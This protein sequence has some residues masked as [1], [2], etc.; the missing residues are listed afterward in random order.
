MTGRTV[1][2]EVALQRRVVVR[3][4]LLRALD[5]SSARARLLVA[6]AGYGKTTLAEQWI[7]AGAR[8]AAW[9]AAR[10]ASAD[11][12]VLSSALAQ[13]AATI[14]DGC[15]AR[16]RE[17]LTST[18][19]PADEAGVL[20]EI[21]AEDLQEWPTDAWLVIDDY[22]RL[23]RATEAEEFV[24]VLHS[25]APVNLLVAS[26]QRPSW[27]SSRAILYGEV[28]ELGQTAL[29]M[30]LEEAEEVLTEWPSEQAS[31]LTRLAEGWP[32]VVG[33][34]GLT[35]VPADLDADVP[36]ELYEF[37]AEE[38]YES[39][40][41]E[42]R[43]GL[44]L[45]AVAPVLD[46]ELAAAILGD[47][48]CEAVFQEALAKGVLDDRHD[49]LELHPLARG[50]LE[51]R[52]PPVSGQDEA[53][54]CALQA[55]RSKRDWDAA[56][57]VL[58]RHGLTHELEGLLE[59]ALDDLLEGARVTTLEAWI[60]HAKERQRDGAIYRIAQAEL[61]VRQGKHRAAQTFAES[62]L[63]LSTI[64][65]PLAF[66]AL[67]IAGRAD[68]VACREAEGLERFRRAEMLADTP[69]ERRQAQLGQ[70][71]C[72]AVLEL[73]ETMSLLEA[74][75]AEASL[76][77]PFDLIRMAERRLSV[78]FRFGFIKAEDL[79]EARSV[80]ELLPQIRDP[81]VRCSFRS[82]F[83]SALY[84]SAEY[85]RAREV[86][87]ELI[88][89]SGRYRIQI[90]LP[91]GHMLRASAL[92]GLKRY[93][94]AE[95]AVSL[96]DEACRRMNDRFGVLNVYC[97]RVRILLQQGRIAEACA[98]EPPGPVGIAGIDSETVATR[99][100]ALACIG[101]L[102]E[103]RSMAQR[104]LMRTGA[105]DA[106]VLARAVLAVA[107][108]R[109]RSSDLQARAS[110]LVDHAF[111][112]GAIDFLVVAYRSSG[113]LLGLLLASAAARERTLFAL[114][115]SNDAQLADRV[116]KPASEVVDPVHGL[117]KRER[118][119]YTL[120]C[121]GLSN[122]EIAQ[123]LFI[124]ESTVKAHLHHVF[125]KLGIRSRTALALSAVARGP[126]AAPATTSPTDSSAGGSRPSTKN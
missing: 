23:C 6:P 17:R 12:A 124:S 14:A 61:T 3:P 100:L 58:E 93:D 25:S 42:T 73:P 91:Y 15:D 87:E 51:S 57:D 95:I 28:F 45:L 60:R 70:I 82:I 59:V 72:A 105:I 48:Q 126:Y 65:R 74:V 13:A 32:A 68:H 62:G 119:V 40:S 98:L 125:D 114:S 85:A 81:L 107:A 7:G 116:G 54:G 24:R 76:T 37:F 71:M 77:E 26:R 5:G 106:R 97:T 56:F 79:D 50:F 83:A 27:V 38:V 22:E 16:L 109:A 89:D 90:A 2:T 21:L 84:L 52:L 110:E 31:G 49:R 117:T 64:S 69:F 80:A 108:V 115:R 88:K 112:S 96:A 34:A 47:E 30:T 104:A 9:Y 10:N 103:A 4:R 44:A 18:Q 78:G 75:T 122:Q 66:R 1:E 94:E 102:E 111:E 43:H 46:R 113:D 121:Q 39:L 55:Y 20:A 67:L 92:G 118:D 53:L 36:D 101:R 29:A 41:E 35:S 8:P 123:Q 99:A 33:L 19:N 63:A 86:A 120:V 11:V